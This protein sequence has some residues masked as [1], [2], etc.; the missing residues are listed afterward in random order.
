[1]GEPPTS[2]LST[3]LPPPFPTMEGRMR[4]SESD[5]RLKMGPKSQPTPLLGGFVARLLWP[6]HAGHLTQIFHPSSESSKPGQEKS[7]AQTN[8]FLSLS[9][10]LCLSTSLSLVISTLESRQSK[11]RW[12]AP[13]GSMDA[14]ARPANRL[15]EGS[16]H[17][18]LSHSS[19]RR[20]RQGHRAAAGHGH[21]GCLGPWARGCAVACRR[22]AMQQRLAGSSISTVSA[23][24]S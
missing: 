13:D 10:W 6:G 12:L 20:G 23:S 7:M 11:R 22:K 15:P 19:Q 21:A 1:M 17:R 16:S 24:L 3:E 14:P 5:W 9:S 8:L 2:T 4:K 18:L